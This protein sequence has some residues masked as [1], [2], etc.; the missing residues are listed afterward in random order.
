MYMMSHVGHTHMMPRAS[1]LIFV[2]PFMRAVVNV[3]FS[4]IE[5]TFVKYLGILYLLNKVDLVAQNFKY[6][7]S[8]RSKTLPLRVYPEN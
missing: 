5:S 3:T 1:P 4:V 6:M 8:H 7:I 2:W